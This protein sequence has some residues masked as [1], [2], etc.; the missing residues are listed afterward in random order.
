MLFRF[1]FEGKNDVLI[2]Q[3]RRVKETENSML[4][5]GKHHFLCHTD[6]LTF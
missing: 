3:V 4:T 1:Q 2:S 6:D 5:D